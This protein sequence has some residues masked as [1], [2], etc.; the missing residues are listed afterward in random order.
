MSFSRCSLHSVS[1]AGVLGQF[2]Y[3]VEERHALARLIPYNSTG[4]LYRPQRPM[5]TAQFQAVVTE[6]RA[7]RMSV[8]RVWHRPI[9]LLDT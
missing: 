5:R 4:F 6:F 9:H 7:R 8:W 2:I 1:R 3:P